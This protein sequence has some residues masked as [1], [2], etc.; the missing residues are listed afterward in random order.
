VSLPAPKVLTLAVLWTF[1]ACRAVMH[2]LLRVF[3]CELIL[4]A[5]CHKYGRHV[6]TGIY[7]PW[8][9]GRGRL[10]LGNN[11]LIGGWCGITFAA[12][13]STSPT[14]SIG[15]DSRVGHN[16]VFTVGK[17]ITIGRHCLIASDVWFF[18]SAG[19]PADPELRLAGC[20]PS[21]DEV[22]PVCVGD[23][24]WIG[25]RCIIYPG[26]SIGAGSVIA[27]G[28]VVMTSVPPN[29]LVG[30]NPARRLGALAARDVA[31]PAPVAG[32]TANVNTNGSGRDA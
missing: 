15:D 16:C 28:S 29:S 20:A 4:K 9:Q 22:R 10:I 12:R 23:N 18:D 19:H 11:V 26:V 7:V 2:F 25:R 17:S 27:A 6:R 3:L 30:G 31:D 1:L 24:V 14:L 8:V 32:H 21:P 13:F 5:Y